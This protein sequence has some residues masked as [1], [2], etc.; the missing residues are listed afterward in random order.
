MALAID[1][2]EMASMSM[3]ERS[4]IREGGNELC[5]PITTGTVR[6]EESEEGAGV[7]RREAADDR[8]DAGECMMG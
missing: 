2:T 5:T 6:Q 1:N 4:E 3:L 8:T 7:S